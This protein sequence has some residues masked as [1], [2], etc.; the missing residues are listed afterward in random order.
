MH[1]LHVYIL[2]QITVLLDHLN[3]EGHLHLPGDIVT[4]MNQLKDRATEIS[5]A[6]TPFIKDAQPNYFHS[7]YLLGSSSFCYTKQMLLSLN[8][9][10]VPKKRKTF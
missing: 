7:K 10:G 2:G 1:Y 3:D 6:A 5:K 9:Q 8:I 4:E